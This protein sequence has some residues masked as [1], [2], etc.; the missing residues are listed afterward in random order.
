MNEKTVK[1]QTARVP[2]LSFE[3]LVR[4]YA[5]AQFHVHRCN[6]LGRNPAYY[7]GL[8]DG[9]K[10][11]LYYVWGYRWYEVEGSPLYDQA[12]IDASHGWVEDET[13]D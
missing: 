8:S 13:T 11:G 3:Q 1:V 6:K 7:E 9:L 12:Y 2:T 10:W 4:D 5:D